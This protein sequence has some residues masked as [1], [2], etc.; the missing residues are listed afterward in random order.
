MVLILL[1]PESKGID[2]EAL[3]Q[4]QKY[5]TTWQHLKKILRVTLGNNGQ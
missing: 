1:P 2:A 5:R 4:V 3:G